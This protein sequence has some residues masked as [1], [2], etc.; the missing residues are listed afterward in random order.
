M[1]GLPEI[2]Y[3]SLSKYSEQRRPLVLTN[4]FAERA[5][6][7]YLATLNSARIEFVDLATEE[8]AAQIMSLIDGQ[9]VILAL[10]G[11]TVLD[12]AK[13]VSRRSGLPLVC[14]PTILSTD[15]IFDDYAVLRKNGFITF[16]PGRMAERVVIDCDLIRSSPKKYTLAGCGDILSIFTGLYDW[17]TTNDLGRQ[18]PD[19]IF[20]PAVYKT[21]EGILDYLL[22]NAKDIKALSPKGIG[23]IADCLAMETLLCN[24]YGSKPAIPEVGGEHFFAHNIYNKMPHF[25][26]GEMVA[27]G[28]VLTAHIQGQDPHPIISF[29]DTIGLDYRPEGISR[30]LI[31]QTLE[32]MPEYVKLHKLRRSVYN[33]FDFQSQVSSINLL[34][35]A[36]GIKE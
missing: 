19:E 26:H 8:K 35:D 33:D 3:A 1:P 14:I 24:S 18:R 13:I 31:R 23:I 32:E 20:S 21:A 10:G 6:K 11:G 17:K 29:M 12:V 34:L 22:E 2:V 25:L 15:A 4:S 30:K 36:I 7:T 5:A 9:E 16:E 27:L 28:V